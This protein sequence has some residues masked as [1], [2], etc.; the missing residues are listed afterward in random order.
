M[1]KVNATDA[2]NLTPQ[3]RE[4]LKHMERHGSISLIAGLGMGITRLAARINDLR[5]AGF[6]IVTELVP[7][8]SKSRYAVYHLVPRT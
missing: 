7:D 2:L 4:V 5:N 1:A 3:A 6:N 8:S